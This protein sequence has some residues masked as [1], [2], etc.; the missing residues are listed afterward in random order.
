MLISNYVRHF[1]VDD[2]FSSFSKLL[3]RSVAVKSVA[4]QNV[5]RSSHLCQM[6]NH[7]NGRHFAHIKLIAFQ[8]QLAHNQTQSN[9]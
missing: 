9:S 5:T 1:T 2:A 8:N 3:S 7:L 6:E 4:N